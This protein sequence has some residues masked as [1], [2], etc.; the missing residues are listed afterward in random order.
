MRRTLP[1]FLRSFLA[2]VCVLLGF[3]SRANHIAGMQL[4]Y[5]HV[6][7]NTYRVYVVAIGDCG[8]ASPSLTTATPAICLF[9]G[10][11]YLRSKNLP[12]FGAGTEITPVCAT[13]LTTCSGGTV[14]GYK[15]Y[16]TSDTFQLSGTS[17]LWRFVFN[18]GMGASSA[19]R[20][21]GLSNLSG[22]VTVIRLV[23]TLNNLTVA[24]NS[25]PTISSPFTPFFCQSNIDNFNPGAI[26]AEGDNL[27][28]STFQGL[29]AGFS[30]ASSDGG[31]TYTY[32]SGYSASAPLGASASSW[33][34]DPITGQITFVPIAAGKYVVDYNIRETRGGI[35]VGNSMLELNFIIQACSAAPPSGYISSSTGA[36]T[37]TDSTHYSICENSGAY[38]FHVLGTSP[39]GF[40]VHMTA[41]G[42]PAGSTF[43]VAS[44]STAAPDGTFTWT[45]TGITPGTYTF[46]VSYK[47]DQCPVNGTNTQA[48]TITV[49]P[50][51]TTF[52]GTFVVC[53]G[54]TTTVGNTVAGGTWVSA[55]PAV[56]TVDLTTGVITG[57]AAGTTTITY[58]SAAG[59]IG[60]HVVT[61]NLSPGPITGVLSV[62]EGLTTSLGNSIAGGTWMS[63]DPSVA[64]IGISSG[65][66]TGNTAGITTISYT[67]S[68]G[69]YSTAQLTVNVTP[70]AITGTATVCVGQ[71]TT[72]ADLVSGG[73]W[74]SS[75]PAIASVGSSTGVVTGNAAGTATITYATGAG[76]R[77]L[78]V[79]TVN[80][81]PAA[82]NPLAA[83]TICVGSSVTLTDATPLGT[84][85]SSNTSVATITSGGVTTG[86]SAGTATISYI[87]SA[88]GCYAIKNVTVNTAPSAITPASSAICVGN[89]TTLTNGVSGG[90]WTSSNSAIAT[91]GSSTGVVT[92]VTAGNVNITYAIGT[93][94]VAATVTVNANPAAINP[95]AATTLCVGNVVTFSDVTP[96]GTWS[97]STPSV[98][99]VG[100]T[101]GSVTAISAG[102]ATITYMLATGCYAIKTVTVNIAPSAIT[103][104]SA[105]VCVGATTT[106]TNSVS[107]GAWTSSNTAV[108]TVGSTSGVVTGVSAGT[109]NITYAIG[110]CTVMATVTVNPLPAAITGTPVVCVGFTTT[111]ADATP[112]G[113]WSSSNTAIATVGTSGIVTGV[114]SGTAT[115][116]YTLPTGCYTITVVTVNAVP[117]AIAGTATVCTG[118]TTTLSDA[119]PG[120][121]W[122][123]SN[124]AVATVGTSSGVV[125]GMSAGTSTISYSVGS[126][127]FATRVVT[128]NASPAA[129]TGTTTVCVG[130]TTPL[131]DGT[132][133]GTWTSSNTAIATVGSSTGVV[134]G[135]AGGTATISY[136]LASGCYAITT[137]SVNAL[138]A[139]GTISGPNTLCVGSFTI[140]TDASPG[141]VWSASNS[142][143]T[144]TGG[145]VA[146]GVTAGTVTISY[147][148][149][150]SCGTA[151]ATKVVTVVAA[152]VAGT[153][154]GP[155]TVCVGSNISLTSSAP[156]GTWSSSN[157]AVATI[158]SSTGV[159]TGVTAGAVIIT[160]SVTNVCGTATATYAVT[161][162]PLGSAGTISGPS[163][164]CVAGTITLT[165]TATGG[166]W[167]SSNSNATVGSTTGAVTGVN[168]GI[169]TITY[170]VFGACGL[171]STT[172]VVT[173]N[174]L[175]SAGTISGPA[176]VCV[177]SVIT[178]SDG[179][180][181]GVWTSS[182]TNATVSGSGIVTGV[183]GGGV[184]ITYTVSN[185][186]GT[187]TA[188]KTLTVI[189][190]PVA[191]T[192]SGPD[193]VCI[194]TTMTLSS[195]V[196]GGTWVAGNSNATV[197]A[198]GVVTGVTSG[199]VPITY[200]VTNPCGSA[201]AVKVI[202][203]LGP[204]TAGTLSGP[205]GVCLG[206]GI[207]LV[208]SVAGGSWFA[209]N[210]NAT[211][212]AP[213][214]ILGATVGVDT[215]FYTV[216]NMCG[217]DVTS[218]VVSVNPIP[219]VAA[220]AGPTAQCIGTT[221]AKMNTT[222]GGVWTSSDM[223]I[224][225]VGLSTGIV[226]GVAAGAI[227]ITYTVTN[228]FGC[229]A[230]V[231]A[232][233]TVF[234]I[235]APGS[236]VGSGNIC[237]GVTSTLSN[238]TPGGTWSSSSPAIATIG[239]AGDITGVAVGTATISYTVS[240]LCGI[241][242]ITTVVT[243]NPLPTVAGITGTAV[244]CIGG[245]ST[246]SDATAGGTWSS[247]DITI[248]MVGSST[249]VVTGVSAGTVVIAYIVT[250][251]VG[252]SASAT[253]VDTVNPL[254]TVAAI[255]GLTTVCVGG[256]I[257]LSDATS[258][259]T[260]SSSDPAVATVGA[261][262]GIVTGIA[263]G[264]FVVTYSYTDVSGCTGIAT[265]V[266][267]V[268]LAPPVLPITGPTNLCVGSTA[269]MTDATTGG[270]W[271]TWS[272]STPAVATIDA[273][274]GV[275]NAIAAGTTIISYN[276]ISAS[277]C[278]S[279]V[280]TT[281]TV[282]ALPSVAPITGTAQE[283]VGATTT[284]SDA[285][286]GGTWSSADV[287]IATVG[288]TTGVV[289][290]VAAGTVMIT[291]TYTN[292][293]GCSGTVSVV[294][295]VNPLP[296]VA[297]ITGT[298]EECLGS[299]TTLANATPGG[300]W[301]SGSTAIATVDA[302]GVVTGVAAGTA[303]ISYSVPGP[304]GCVG[305][306][307]I[308]NTVSIVP[309][310]APITG[311]SSVCVGGTGTLANT[312]AGGTW[313]SDNTSIA[314]IASST[315]IVTGIAPG[316]VMIRY[317][318]VN[319]C[320]SV[321]DSTII[322]V[323]SLPT[324]API[325]A[326]SGGTVCSGTSSLLSDATP[327]GT[328]SSG[329]PSVATVGV[330]SG[331]VT[332]V[333][334]GTATITYKVTAST[335]CT[336]YATYVVTVAASMP[337]M[338]VLPVGT[339]TLCDSMVHMYVNPVISGITYQWMRNG[340]II[341]GATNYDYLADSP[342]IYSVVVSN[343]ICS[344]VLTGTT[345]MTRPNATI[346]FN[347]PNILFTG[348][349]A[350][351]QWYLNGVAISGA[352]T[353]IVTIS[354]NGLYTVKVTDVN[355]CS[356]SSDA[357]LV[358][359]S[360]VAVTRLAEVKIYPNPATSVLH[361][362]SPVAVTVKLMSIDGKLV[363]EQ[364]EAKDI[365]V[366]KLA[367]GLY[368]IMVYDQ[369]NQ[370]LKTSKFAKT[371]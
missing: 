69:C 112:A 268:V 63:A 113:T 128:V 78:R 338:G 87:L 334:T 250:S 195:T 96:A 339:A 273:T 41:S 80:P 95:V 110:T 318:V 166:V 11:T 228:S 172:K 160:Y 332:G 256:M 132:P 359:P 26:D 37:I 224:A 218:K 77:A 294:N 293:L 199:S 167:S 188:T 97:S 284:L 234:A 355:G 189:A 34:F 239:T 135:V 120:G 221:I 153:V 3:A 286:A 240:N 356:D 148:V 31:G 35:F 70:T 101:T 129:I 225:T 275:V 2:S 343:G 207:T 115:I 276:F 361:I 233:D 308:V 194:G 66:A 190:L 173:I 231:T 263:T 36:G 337:A 323:N 44:D 314:T 1:L 191:G 103:P 40:N 99:T 288:S 72:L 52:T 326:V 281:L 56:A 220:I 127:C 184:I 305:V 212:V 201:T 363:A 353:S 354:G 24:S 237:L 122:T 180:T 146:T 324:V 283:C 74:S 119:T 331:V 278:S 151:S 196:A 38:S 300:T 94:T 266:D 348:S 82:I 152:P 138:A 130:G 145:G 280:T 125:T 369:D 298:A 16:V 319:M 89:T 20:V 174:G 170:T 108:A 139:V 60:T 222:P 50:M 187:A 243:V 277:G 317:T 320:G 147:T 206:S 45:S 198:S 358:G 175:P 309:P 245:T 15:K 232:P 315:G 68:D 54:Q 62:C 208:P 236:I 254:P 274:T 49:N 255:S 183:N 341:P 270:T 203:V 287:T 219:T 64:S 159:L 193:S 306:A 296:A 214:V 25:S 39:G 85:S 28:Y 368:M 185:S 285:T 322:T 297:P 58:T 371:E 205:S 124:T 118:A 83:T 347:P 165:S 248:A 144:I 365:D 313:S 150:N 267:T 290:G 161:V 262:T 100:L 168:P 59:C 104:S 265:S 307:T 17:A 202:V 282:N 340:V 310:A 209:S 55:N 304:F 302:T 204:P 27:S 126:G 84:W 51:P 163:S 247:S 215:I 217:T 246:L 370:L 42:L 142:N 213:G 258:G 155:T 251:A 7:G 226:T 345:V 4:Y 330:T 114:L 102:T 257:T 351:Y 43:S 76:C 242:I 259:G 91:V 53:A 301:S 200:T 344:Q 8:I 67:L 299:T 71:T 5:E 269:T 360:S 133:G 134:A 350:S 22:A 197:D 289:T 291:Y 79:V 211:I 260:W 366:S 93:C 244:Q 18:G 328:W 116:S 131:A 229:P 349:F 117:A 241:A 186:C 333:S 329:N 47:D 14:N 109:S 364:K 12:A 106:L 235:P 61:V 140:Y 216:T 19:G 162:N 181:G 176:S 164:V 325:T 48:F 367:N 336:N 227:T 73:T 90:T 105:S 261:S 238:A 352:T 30:C 46:Y 86:V 169:D 192:L 272:S 210:T 107:G 141:G 264:T 177:G 9:N 154:S 253:I 179:V 136:T 29:V 21:T 111:L 32:A 292:S 311:S 316:T 342:G 81:N 182:N 75:T 327:G 357:Y 6:S 321:M 346:G 171:A 158:G 123:S 13:T 33:T 23:D 178:L 312:V 252:C 230:S 98:A 88:T 92:G 223:S 143:A 57:I 362:E 137:V 335:G 157:T 249:G 121:I 149:T 295:T 156:G 303:V 271:G 279:I 65:V 10:S